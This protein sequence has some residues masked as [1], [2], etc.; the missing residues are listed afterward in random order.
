MHD[1]GH[2]VL[3]LVGVLGPVKT[4][5]HPAQG[6][7]AGGAQPDLLAEQVGLGFKIGFAG[8]ADSERAHRGGKIAG[9]L[10]IEELRRIDRADVGDGGQHGRAELELGAQLA[11]HHLAGGPGIVPAGARVGRQAQREFVNSGHRSERL[12]DAGGERRP[13]DTCPGGRRRQKRALLG[14]RGRGRAELVVGVLEAHREPGPFPGVEGPRK[15]KAGALLA[16]HVRAGE[17]VLVEAVLVPDGR[18]EAHEQIV[19]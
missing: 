2:R 18:V 17:R 10:R 6:A 15:G 4:P 9:A 3:V 13:N 5:Q 12:I 16:A 7:F 19:A 11:A 14:R 8:H 1:A